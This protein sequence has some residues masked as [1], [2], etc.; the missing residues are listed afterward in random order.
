M[1]K[2]LIA[3]SNQGKIKEIKQRFAKY[4]LEILGLGDLSQVEEV[5]EDGETFKANALKKA[6]VRAQRTCLNTL[7]DDSGLVV[8]YLD[9]SPGVYSA[10]FAGPKATDQENNQKLLSKLKGVPKEKRTAHF[11]CVAALV[12][13]EENVEITVSGSCSG[14]ITEKPR[15][16]N[17]F[18]YDPLF[19]VPEYDKTMAELPLRIKNKISHRAEAL[20]KIETKIK[21]LLI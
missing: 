21:K 14:I 15:G 1:L 20:D 7:A 3:S 16:K 8:D 19:Y 10:R 11:K 4:E 5:I 13:P 6:R 9:G 2:L 12:L 18:G 17:G